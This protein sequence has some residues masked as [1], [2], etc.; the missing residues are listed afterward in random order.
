MGDHVLKNVDAF[1]TELDQPFTHDVLK[2]SLKRLKN[3][4]ASSFDL[5]CN[6]MLKYSGSAMES[7]LLAVFNTCLSHCMIAS[8]WR[9]D[10]LRPLFKSG[11]KSDPN[12]F[13]G[14]CVSSCVG[15]VLNS[16]LRF[17]LEKFCVVK[18]H[19]GA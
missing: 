1:Q 10:Q 8:Q 7:A 16:M 14:I 9:K 15:K 3:N 4:K 18:G 5:V 13:R 17:R 19:I 2:R 12:N 6:E 11:T